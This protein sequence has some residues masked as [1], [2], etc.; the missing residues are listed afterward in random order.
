MPAGAPGKGRS[1]IADCVLRASVESRRL[2][3]P[4]LLQVGRSRAASRIVL[5][6]GIVNQYAPKICHNYDKVLC[7]LGQLNEIK[8]ITL[9]LLRYKLN[10]S[11]VQV[12][13]L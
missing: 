5:P 3:L 9:L 12:C 10:L 4:S 8:V 7:A 6:Y 13:V 2:R 11:K 1:K